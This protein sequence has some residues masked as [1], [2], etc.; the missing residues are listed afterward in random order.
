MGRLL[1]MTTTNLTGD[2]SFAM[3]YE[4][5]LVGSALKMVQT[6]SNLDGKAQGAVTTWAYDDRYRLTNETV[7]TAG[8]SPAT[9]ATSYTWD[10]ADNRL[11]MTKIVDDASIFVVTTTTYT[12][13]ALNQM[14]GW[15]DGSSSA[16]YAYDANGV[17]TNMVRTA[18]GSPATTSYTYDEDN[19]LVQAVA[20]VGDL[21]EGTSIFAYD[22]RSRRYYR[23]TPDSPNM[24]CV[25]D[26]GLSIQEHETASADLTLNLLTPNTVRTEF[27]RGEG[28]GGGVGGMVYSI[29]G[30]SEIHH[31]KSAILSARTPT[32][33]VM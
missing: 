13:N 17:R 18:G 1:T 3:A 23:S 4:Y 29:K 20:G 9:N 19:R 7:C 2:G 10:D 21:G 33:A 14:V 16:A 31:R 25:F 11:P 5:D 22:Y 26:G 6:S 32:T 15:D 30:Q 24:F 27:V 12:N 8:I 28:M